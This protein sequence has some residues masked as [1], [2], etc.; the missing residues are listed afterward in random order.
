MVGGGCPR[1]DKMSSSNDAQQ[2]YIFCLNLIQAYK[3]KVFIIYVLGPFLI[4]S[5]CV[6]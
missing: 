3:L 6:K 1:G 2:Y 5:K 4:S